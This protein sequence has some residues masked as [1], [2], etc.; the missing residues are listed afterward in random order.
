[1]GQAEIALSGSDSS[2]F[3]GLAVMERTNRGMAAGANNLKTCATIS[4]Q[5]GFL[6]FHNRPAFPAICFYVFGTLAFIKYLFRCPK[7]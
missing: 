5:R 4:L 7:Q 2:G 6:V 3:G 1:L